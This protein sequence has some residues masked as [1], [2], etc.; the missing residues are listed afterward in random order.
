MCWILSCFGCGFML[1]MTPMRPSSAW[2]M[3][4]FCVRDADSCSSVWR[5]SNRERKNTWHVLVYQPPEIS[6]WIRDCNMKKIDA[7]FQKKAKIG[8]SMMYFT[9][10]S[11]WI[12]HSG[13]VLKAWKKEPWMGSDQN[14]HISMDLHVTLLDNILM[15]KCMG[16]ISKLWWYAT[17]MPDPHTS[18]KE[19]MLQDFKRFRCKLLNFFCRLWL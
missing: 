6:Q 10:Q 18:S 19:G 12:M 11:K 3:A 14:Q 13:P 17:S 2:C 5:S 4:C 15:M 1:Y 16:T 7:F 9:S 8:I